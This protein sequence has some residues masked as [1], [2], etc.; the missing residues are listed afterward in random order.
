MA[1]FLVVPTTSSPALEPHLRALQDSEKIKFQQ[2]P[3]GEFFVSYKGASQELSD[4]L[5]I[6]DGSKGA[7]VVASINSYY[8]YASN[9]LWEWLSAHWEH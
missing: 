4:L 1:I 7:G 9:N 3:K 6:S 5:G 2:L 8:G